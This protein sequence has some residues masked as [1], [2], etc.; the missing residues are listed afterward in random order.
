MRGTLT[1][2]LLAA[3]SVEAPRAGEPPASG[4]GVSVAPDT[5]A[6]SVDPAEVPTAS[7][8]D[9]ADGQVVAW[10]GDAWSC[11]TPAAADYTVFGSCEAGDKVT[12]IDAKTGAVECDTDLDM[13]TDSLAAVGACDEDEVLK[14]QDGAWGCGADDDAAE[15]DPIFGASAAGYLTS[16]SSLN[17]SLLASGTVPFARLPVG[18]SATQVAAGDHGHA[19]LLSAA[20]VE[21][22]LDDA[23]AC[24]RLYLRNATVRRY[25]LSNNPATDGFVLCIDRN[26]QM[27]KVGDLWIDRY[28]D[29]LVSETIWNTGECD[30]SGYASSGGASPTDDYPAGFPDNGNWSTPVY[31]CSV[32]GVVPSRMMTWFQAQAACTL[33]GKRLCTNAEWQ[34]A[35]EGTNDP[36]SFNGATGGACHT[37]G[38]APRGMAMAG[39][40]PGGS[41]SCISRW[42]AE[43]MIGNLWEWVADWHGK[44]SS[45]N[46]LTSDATYGNDYMYDVSPADSQGAAGQNF[47]AAAIRGGHWLNGTDAGAFAL[48]L[49]YGPSCWST[50]FGVRC[51]A[52]ASR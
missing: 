25:A 20:D 8:L 49:S 27:V 17:A 50:S 29:A 7:A 40:T 33:A 2:L 10:S 28:E 41:T 3:C 37:G 45:T 5:H 42:G 11:A 48:N 44:D 4:T 15:S 46:G 19:G 18:T 52:G 39:S 6:V 13:D 22:M 36:G 51:C 31:A 34:A 9:C 23:A 14:W 24:P 16:S 35:V 21:A 38:S 26:D 30:G 32:A 43:D 12:G 1:W 47:P